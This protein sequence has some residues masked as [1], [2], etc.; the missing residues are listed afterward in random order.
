MQAGKVSPVEETRARVALANVQV[1]VEQARRELVAARKRLALL[2]NDRAPRFDR[3]AGD[4][5]QVWAL[6]PYERLV[7]RA[8]DNPD[9]ARWATQSS[10]AVPPWRASVPK[11]SLT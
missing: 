5:E 9:L 11:R 2:W 7:E 8:L 1:E 6:P 4:L 3:A 10:S